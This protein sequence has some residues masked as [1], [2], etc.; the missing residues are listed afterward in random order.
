MVAITTT[1]VSPSDTPV[2]MLSFDKCPVCA[3]KHKSRCIETHAH[4]HPEPGIFYFDQCQQCKLVFLNPRVAPDCLHKYYDKYYLPYRGASAWG[5]YASFVTYSQEKLDKTR[6]RLAGKYK[7]LNKASL[8]LDIGCG[9]PTFLKAC[10]TLYNCHTMGIDFSDHGWQDTGHKFDG[11]N[12][13]IAQVKDL[14]AATRP[15]VITMW[16][17][18]EHDYD[19]ILSLSILRKLAQPD[20]IL[21]IEV[22]NYD[23]ESRRKYGRYWAGYHTPRHTFLFS[24]HNIKLLLQKTG[25]QVLHINTRGTLDPYNLYWMSEMEQKGIDWQKDMTSEFWPYVYGMIGFR[26][27]NLFTRNRSLGV[28]TVAARI[29]R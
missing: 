19:P 8:I 14:N 10:D 7:K 20:T 15:D 3:S 4:M 18:L 2:S 16:H 21:L 22:P 17:Y 11:L 5:K 9:Q 6:A 29:S 27:K 1:P 12:L 25:W 13:Q 24:P 23:S 28:M 26:V